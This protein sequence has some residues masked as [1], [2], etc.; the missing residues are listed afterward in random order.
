MKRILF[1]VICLPFVAQSQNG[2]LILEGVSPYLYLN[3]TVASKENYY[4][5]GRLYNV[6]PKTIAPYNKMQMDKGLNPGQVL[7]IPVG[8]SN[9]SPNG[10]AAAGEVLVP[11]YYSVKEKEGLYRIGFNHNKVSAETLKKWNDLKS[12]TVGTGTMLVV[13]YLKVRKNESALAARSIVKG[14]E[15]KSTAEVNP[16]PPE[17]NQQ[18]VSVDSTVA[19]VKDQPSKKEEKKEEMISLDT[20]K[21]VSPVNQ[22]EKEPVKP[23]HITG[24]DFQGGVFKSLYESQTRGDE[25][26]T[27]T[28]LGGVFKSTSGWTDGKY[29]CLHNT[30]KTGSII[31]VTNTANGKSV[32]A[33][34]LDVIPDIKKNSILLIRLSNAAADEL[35]VGE[36]NFNCTLNYSK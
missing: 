19:T 24:I 28:G 5:I 26:S 2:S 32:Y 9:L 14:A 7:K 21:K 29:Y 4:S 10:K 33:K 25:V 15:K 6:G 3:H 35:S 1:F 34:V 17:K 20:I 8:E 11:L 27:E 31:K 18:H 16:A 30:A 22:D 23:V 36:A 12:L 13:G